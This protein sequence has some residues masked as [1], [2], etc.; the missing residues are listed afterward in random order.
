MYI[1]YKEPTQF[2]ATV[3]PIYSFG[4][5]TIAKV[6][7]DT[8]N[9]L[10]GNVKVLDRAMVE[11]GANHYGKNQKKYYIRADGSGFSSSRVDSTDEKVNEPLTDE[12]KEASESLYKL[13]LISNVE[14]VFHD[15]FKA[16]NNDRP[17]LESSTWV[18]Q[19]SE[20]HAYLADNTVGTPVL[21]ALANARGITIEEQANKVIAK[22]TTFNV[23]VA[24]LL[25]QQQV[26][27]DQIKSCNDIKELCKW[28]EDNFCV[29]MNR[30]WAAE[31]DLLDENDFRKV[32]VIDGVKF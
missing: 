31:Y 13:V 6:E 1:L 29:M 9:Y 20:A 2:P 19:S 22:E 10:T 14:D 3:K 18:A 16:L 7:D 25:G 12:E 4:S 28:N 30:D 17:E 5:R 23:E 15:R 11:I 24:T 21:S 26:L 27:T 8:F 32:P